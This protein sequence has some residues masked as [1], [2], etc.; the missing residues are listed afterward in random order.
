MEKVNAK[1]IALFLMIVGLAVA[2]VACQGAV[3]KAGTDGTVGPQGPQGPPGDPGDPGDLG[4]GAFR[5]WQTPVLVFIN[6]SKNADDMI[7]PGGMKTVD[8]SE[9]HRGGLGPFSYKVTE[10]TA[11]TEQLILK[12]TLS[13]DGDMLTVKLTVTAAVPEEV[14]EQ[15]EPADFVITVTD[16]GG[17]E[18]P[19]PVIA[20]RNRTPTRDDASTAPVAIKVGMSGESTTDKDDAIVDGYT[21]PT[22][23]KVACK[24]F[25]NCTY[26]MDANDFNDDDYGPVADNTLDTLSALSY[27]ATSRDTGKASVSVDGGKLV[28]MGHAATRKR[29]AAGV[30]MP[31]AADDDAP[32]YIGV[33]ATDRGDLPSDKVEQF[34]SVTVDEPPVSTRTLAS[35]V[36]EL[37][38]GVN[39]VAVVDRAIVNN[40]GLFFDDCETAD[41]D[42]EFYAHSSDSDAVAITGLD[43]TTTRVIEGTS[44]AKIDTSALTITANLRGTVTITVAVVDSFGQA[45]TASFTLEVVNPA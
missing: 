37:P 29:D 17:S 25:D 18:V 5:A 20:S 38:L 22:N 2:M 36:S 4:T 8:L 9:Y 32:V 34:L 28:V 39:G 14:D 23:T 7:A 24:T 30:C 10:A 6:D 42:L 19:L 41:T 11:D 21:T 45:E 27:S 3:G 1:K 35:T 26:T 44:F 31:S 43:G 13:D 33:T 16:A 40:L 12:E 15:Y